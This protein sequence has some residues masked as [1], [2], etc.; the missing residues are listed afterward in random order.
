MGS[1]EVSEMEAAKDGGNPAAEVSIA[2]LKMQAHMNI[3]KWVVS[4]DGFNLTN[5]AKCRKEICLPS[6]GHLTNGVTP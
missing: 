6:G 5:A 4:R 2:L 3:R 1:R